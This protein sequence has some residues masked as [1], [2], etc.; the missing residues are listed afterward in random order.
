MPRIIHFFQILT[1]LCLFLFAK[2]ALFASHYLG[3][4]IE[5]SRISGNIYQIQLIVF[6]DCA[7]TSSNNI[8]NI[9]VRSSLCN[10]NQTLSLP[11][12]GSPTDISLLC[13][14]AV[15]N[16]TNANGVAG[17]IQRV[18]Y[19]GQINLANGCNDWT[20]TWVGAG[21]TSA[22]N[23]LAS[24]NN[25]N[26]VLRSTLN[27]TVSGSNNSPMF[28]YS[29]FT[30]ICQGQANFY[31]L[32]AKDVDGDSLSYAL[33]P[34]IS[35]VGTYPALVNANYVANL[36]GTVPMNGI[37]TLSPSSGNMGFTP[38]QG[39]NQNV[40]ICVRVTQWRNGIVIGATM[41]EFM[42][43]ANIC[44]N[45]LPSITNVNNLGVISQNFNFCNSN[46][47]CFQIT[48]TDADALQNIQMQWGGEIPN[49][50]FTVVSVG[51]PS[52][53]NFC[54]QPTTQDIGTKYFT[55]Q[56]RDDACPSNG[57]NIFAYQLNVSNSPPPINSIQTNAS[58]ISPKTY[59]ICLGEAPNFSVSNSSNATFVW[60]F[61]GAIPNPSGS[62]TSVSGA[63]FNI[64]GV[65][66]IILES[67]STCF[68][69]GSNKDTIW[70]HVLNPPTPVAGQRR[71]T[72]TQGNTA[73]L[74][75][76]GLTPNDL[77]TWSPNTN[78][79][80][81]GQNTAN[82]RPSVT[83]AYTA[84]IYSRANTNASG[85]QSCAASVTF[86]VGV[87]PRLRSLNAAKEIFA[88]NN[89]HDPNPAFVSVN[90]SSQNEVT[91]N[92]F[93]NPTS[94]KL[95]IETQGLEKYPNFVLLDALGRVVQTGSFE[96]SPTVQLSLKHLS[97]GIY[98]LKFEYPDAEPVRIIKQ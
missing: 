51:N 21:R 69:M 53:A 35:G 85:L 63:F 5:Y 58:L 13:P 90:E 1:C 41:Q 83:T 40:S 57:S 95:I 81:T 11:R 17:G 54:W 84:T 24:P 27:N 25:P 49:A 70:L 75:L 36:S 30:Q 60:N 43:F 72:I 29:P 16:C 20:L 88:E 32:G 96:S 92:I 71:I 97:S 89:Q 80:V 42:L 3:G 14:N 73:G 22:T 67:T 74:V 79:T 98:I 86:A 44:T 34:C 55:V 9:I 48:A 7:G 12:I 52:I 46:A 45:T 68:S 15:S 47:S 2:S 77:V 56:V 33:I 31:N 93:P 23:L 19:A 37:T 76:A 65:F 4:N 6:R 94:D 59:Q 82:V 64:A 66:P 26:I 91:A 28:N 10:F 8:E 18:V 87:L 50:S 78:I 39:I 62:A 38:T 61:S